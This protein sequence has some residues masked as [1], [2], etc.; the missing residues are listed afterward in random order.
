LGLDKVDFNE[1]SIFNSL[2]KEIGKEEYRVNLE[3][4][5]TAVVYLISSERES[6]KLFCF[7]MKGFMTLI[8]IKSLLEPVRA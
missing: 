3:S 1:E 7:T 5:N 6:T 8:F 4:E 2:P